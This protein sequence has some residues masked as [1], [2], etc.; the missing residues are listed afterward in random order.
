MKRPE[1]RPGKVYTHKELWGRDRVVMGDEKG[2]VR[3]ARVVH[4]GVGAENA[5]VGRPFTV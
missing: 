2:D 4:G 1:T 3:K 5:R